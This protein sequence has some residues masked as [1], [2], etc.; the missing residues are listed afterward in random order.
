MKTMPPVRER[1][2]P[3]RGSPVRGSAPAAPPRVPRAAPLPRLDLAGAVR[4]PVGSPRRRPQARG[5]VW[6]LPERCT[7]GFRPRVRL[8]VLLLLMVSSLLVVAGRLVWVQGVS[9]GHFVALASGQRDR[10]VILAARRGSIVDRNGNTLAMSV[11][12]K[13]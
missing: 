6:A 8:I 2:P 13:T 3:L 10:T 11:D 5:Q 9:S 7:G 1:R 4:R 12:A